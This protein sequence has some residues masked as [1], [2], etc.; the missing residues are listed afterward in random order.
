MKNEEKKMNQTETAEINDKDL[1]QVAGGSV[2]NEG[3]KAIITGTKEE[4][5][6]VVEKI[7]YSGKTEVNPATA[8]ITN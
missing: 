2:Q 4:I 7:N 5:E 6:T 3:D 8:M 1:E